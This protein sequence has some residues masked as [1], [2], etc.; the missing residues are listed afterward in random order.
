MKSGILTYLDWQV[1]TPSLKIREPRFSSGKLQHAHRS[2]A[3]NCVNISFSIF[4]NGGSKIC[5][6]F[7]TSR[8][9][10]SEESKK[11]Y[12][13]H[14]YFRASQRH[15]SLYHQ[16]ETGPGAEKARTF[17]DTMWLYTGRASK[18]CLNNVY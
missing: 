5:Q 18:C 12:Q 15:A 2:T 7:L 6:R 8:L 10:F 9:V 14:G 16:K 1:S 4:L 11:R 17:S 3:L 13:C